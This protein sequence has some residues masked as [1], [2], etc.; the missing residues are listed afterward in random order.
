MTVFLLRPIE[1]FCIELCDGCTMSQ[2][3]FS[4][5]LEFFYRS[6]FFFRIISGAKTQNQCQNKTFPAIK[7]VPSFMTVS[8]NSRGLYF[9]QSL[10][11]YAFLVDGAMNFF[12]LIMSSTHF[13]FKT[14]ICATK[15]AK[16]FGDLVSSFEI[17]YMV[18]PFLIVL[19]SKFKMSVMTRPPNSAT[20]WTI[21]SKSVE[22]RFKITR[23]KLTFE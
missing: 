14:G 3:Q 16:Y 18:S 20:P 9:E 4:T 12:C 2:C 7:P 8:L 21:R 13:C 5:K 6:D 17:Q 10:S 11:V 1:I 15:Q 22:P 23:I 19:I